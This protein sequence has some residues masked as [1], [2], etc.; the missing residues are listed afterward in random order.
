MI[1][2]REAA[3]VTAYTGYLIGSFD[4]AHKYIEEI[5]E[6]PVYSHE[7]ASKA[8]MEEI[9]KKAKQDFISM[10][11]EKAKEWIKPPLGIQPRYIWESF[12]LQ[13]L[14]EAIERYL[15]VNKTIPLKWIE[16]FNELVAKKGTNL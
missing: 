5:M 8:I 16:E 11:V 4:E 7:M 14:G 15:S 10:D 3:I 13:E 6:R 9:R 2:K 12:R 1:T